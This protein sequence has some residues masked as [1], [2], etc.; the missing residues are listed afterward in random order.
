[1]ACRDQ[2]EI[3][4]KRNAAVLRD[5]I[6]KMDKHMTKMFDD[7][8]ATIAEQKEIRRNQDDEAKV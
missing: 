1:M 3:T 6:D 5:H 4:V 7:M 2:I 8:L